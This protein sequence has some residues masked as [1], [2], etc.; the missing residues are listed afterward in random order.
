MYQKARKAKVVL[1]FLFL[2]GFL[3][4]CL[5]LSIAFFPPILSVRSDPPD[6]S[7]YVNCKKKDSRTPARM[8]LLSIFGKS[9][10]V[11]SKNGYYPVTRDAGFSLFRR[12]II[13]DAQ[14]EQETFSSGDSN[15]VV[16][17]V[18]GSRYPEIKVMVKVK[19]Q[20]G[21]LVPDLKKENI[22]LIE[23]R[24]EQCVTTQ[25]QFNL[26]EVNKVDIVFFI[27][28]TGSMRGTLNVVKQNIES[29][30]DLLLAQNLNFRLAGYSF[31][32]IVPYKDRFD[33]TPEFT[34]RKEA[35]KMA[36]KF[37]KWLISLKAEE[38]GDV[39]EN[40]LDPIINA[41]DISFNYRADATKI[42]VLITD[43]SAHVAEDGGDS[44]TTATFEVARSKMRAVGMKLYY[45]SPRE[46]Y[47]TGLDAQSLGWPFSAF[48]LTNKFSEEL[49][50]W[51]VI[52]FRDGIAIEKT[53]TRRCNLRVRLNPGE[54]DNSKEYVKDFV[55]YPLVR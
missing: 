47:E 11:V 52:S 12:N 13:I 33:F 41:C 43:T 36:K 40:C 27:D 44:L 48:V 2:L 39:K 14:L 1:F 45:A 21:Q 10:V 37:K 32:D 25:P 8:R 20:E 54:E 46:E 31:D 6:A 30:C 26:R 34:D 3:L 15:I 51:Y 28:V 49:I 17:W 35:R 53:R 23:T 55:F 22:T 19:N 4:C 7:I 38:G 24:E 42:G 50:G 5:V 18:D 9:K 16:G 29:F